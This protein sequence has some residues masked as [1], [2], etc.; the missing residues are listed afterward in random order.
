MPRDLWPP[1]QHLANGAASG[2]NNPAAD[3]HLVYALHLIALAATG[4]G[5]T[6]G[7]G[8]RWAALP[9]VRDHSWLR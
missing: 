8:R 4:A 3:Y 1:A 6:W 9:V 2:S 7:L 5:N